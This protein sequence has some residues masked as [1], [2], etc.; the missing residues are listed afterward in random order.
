VKEYLSGGL[1]PKLFQFLP[2][3]TYNFSASQSDPDLLIQDSRLDELACAVAV[4]SL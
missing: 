3:G 4:A 1:A 2:Q